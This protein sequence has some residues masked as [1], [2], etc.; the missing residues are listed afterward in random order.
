MNWFLVPRAIQ[1][2]TFSYMYFFMFWRKLIKTTFFKSHV[3][4]SLFIYNREN[5][6]SPEP[7]PSFFIN[8]ADINI[9]KRL[10]T[11]DDICN[12]DKTESP[13]SNWEPL[14]CPSRVSSALAAGTSG[15]WSW[16]RTLPNRRPA[17]SGSP[18]WDTR[19]RS[20]S[21]LNYPEGSS[22]HSELNQK[23]TQRLHYGASG[24]FS[25]SGN[26]KLCYSSP[27]LWPKSSTRGRSQHSTPTWSPPYP[28][29]RRCPGF[30][31][32]LHFR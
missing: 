15:S 26:N 23:S 6:L 17:K 5:K 32:R 12:K 24:R 16:Y 25:T 8:P 7:K 4:S 31:N 14:P 3:S 28:R 29:K 20:P 21:S 13:Q 27:S 19:W 1:Q 18:P 10:T 11:P 2:V 9:T 30:W 22:T